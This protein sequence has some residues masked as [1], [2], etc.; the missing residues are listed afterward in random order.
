MVL[1]AGEHVN[2]VTR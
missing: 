2:R 1:K